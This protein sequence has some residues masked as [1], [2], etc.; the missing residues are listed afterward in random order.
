MTFYTSKSRNLKIAIHKLAESIAWQIAKDRG[1]TIT[2]EIRIEA[3]RI[4]ADKLGPKY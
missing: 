4:A 3:K 2:P 1:V